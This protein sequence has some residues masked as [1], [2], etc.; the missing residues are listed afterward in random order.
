MFKNIIFTQ[1]VSKITKLRLVL[2]I[3][4][5]LYNLTVFNIIHKKT[6][7]KRGLALK[8]PNHR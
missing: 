2:V 6:T 3:N 7:V 5:K 8:I 1:M 4:A